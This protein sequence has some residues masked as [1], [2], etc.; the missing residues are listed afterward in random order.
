MRVARRAFLA[1]VITAAASPAVL[2]LAR[3]DAPQVTLK[4]HHFFSSVSSGHEKFLVP[5]ARKVEAGSGGRIRI[6]IFPSMQLGGAPAQLFDQARDGVADIV[7]AVPGQTPGRFAKI[8]AFE[9][10]FLPSRRALVNSR[11]LEDYA[12]VNLQDEFR[13]VR[14]ICFSCRDHGIMHANR[15]IKS[16]ADVKG[17]RLHVPNRLAGEA[18]RALGAQ[19]VTMPIPQ[20]P[21]AIAGGVIDGCLDP[22]D[23]AP[24]LRLSDLLKFHTDFAES[25]LSTSTFV[26]AINKMAYEGLPRDLRAVIDQNSGQGAAAMA[27]TMWDLEARTVADMAGA[28]GE[29]IIMLTA[30][31]VAP[32]RKTTESVIGAWLKQMKEHKLDGGK[33]IANARALVAKYADEPEPQPRQPSPEQKIVTEPPSQPPQQAKPEVTATPKVEAPTAAPA[34]KRPQSKALDIPM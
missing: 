4:L 18:V 8:E 9:L 29:V 3:A 12:A 24:S 11:A 10:P 7:W 2:R 16:V 27:G 32:W 23:V 25:S 33:L 6:D 22:W 19:A 1:S 26:L 13:E 30:E 15:A 20:V 17:L 31:E 34:V 28:R 21:M 5:W 14:P